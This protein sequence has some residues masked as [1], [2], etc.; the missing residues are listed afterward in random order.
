MHAL[1]IITFL[2]CD[3]V[4][5]VPHLKNLGLI[6]HVTEVPKSKKVIST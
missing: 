3:L 5:R 6:R 2:G 1:C 4:E